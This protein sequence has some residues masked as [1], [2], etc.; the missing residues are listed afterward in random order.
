MKRRRALLGALGGAVA[1]AAASGAAAGLA[2]HSG[3][4]GPARLTVSGGYIPRPLLADE[5]AAYVTVSNSGGTDAQL[6]SVTTPLA[7]H[8]TL[9]TTTGTT[10]RQVTSLTVP[11]GGRLVL[12]T[13]GAHMMLETLTHMPSVGERITLMLHFTH[14]TPATVALTVPVRPTTYHPRG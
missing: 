4:G 8:V 11:A 14:A 3:S 12:G 9:H 6:T 5:A 13:G 7:A 1:V 10:M 2:G